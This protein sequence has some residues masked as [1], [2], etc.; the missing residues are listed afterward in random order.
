MN[1]NFSKCICMCVLWTQPNSFRIFVHHNFP[2]IFI[3]F[4]RSFVIRVFFFLVSFADGIV[5]RIHRPYIQYHRR[6]VWYYP[7]HCCLSKMLT[8]VMQANGWVVTL[9]LVKWEY[10]CE[11]VDM[12][13]DATRRTWFEVNEWMNEP[14]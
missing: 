9:V 3:F 7:E 6:S 12:S 8:N 5:Y 2:L 4:F 14:I 10:K 11:C 13:R 1:C